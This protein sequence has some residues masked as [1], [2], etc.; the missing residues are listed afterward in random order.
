MTKNWTTVRDSNHYLLSDSPLESVDKLPAGAYNIQ[1][2]MMGTQA[3]KVALKDE[4]L[5]VFDDGPAK[6]IIQEIQMFW[7]AKDKYTKMDLPYRRGVL[8]HGVPGTGKSGIVRIICDSVIA[9]D[10]LVI[11]VKDASDLHVWL[12][13]LNKQEIDRNVVVV[14][15]DIEQIVRYD[16]QSFLQILDGI[17]NYRPGLVFIG[18]TNHIEEMNSRIYRPSRFDLLIKVQEPSEEIR[19]Q[20]VKALCER[21]NSEYRADIVEASAG[22]SFAHVKEMVVSSLLYEKPLVE[23]KA[24]LE[25][26]GNE[27]DDDTSDDE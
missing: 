26:H 2:G 3:I 22:M 24:R 25:A 8:M 18:T 23:L 19:I 17:D 11:I 14:L 16:E 20:Y 4:K 12:P 15:E 5:I 10:G 21:Y 6:E 27:A 9:D 1:C 7:E 13:I